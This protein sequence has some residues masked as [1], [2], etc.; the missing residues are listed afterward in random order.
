[1]GI[2]YILNLCLFDFVDCVC[3]IINGNGVDVVLNLFF[4]DFILKGFDVLVF[5]GWFLEI[6]KWDVYVDSLI[7]LKVLCRN[8]FLMVIDFVLMGYE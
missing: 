5:Y 1:M 8:V 6:G 7:G 4:V 3:D 2:K